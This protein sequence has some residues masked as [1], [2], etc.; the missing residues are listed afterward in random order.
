[1]LYGGLLLLLYD[2]FSFYIIIYNPFF[3]ASYHLFQK[4][5]VLLMYIIDTCTS[6]Y[7]FNRKPLVSQ[8]VVFSRCASECHNSILADCCRIFLDI[9]L[10]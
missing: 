3:I 7:K 4:W 2:F 8:S 6:W 5:I 1:M 10:S 9:V